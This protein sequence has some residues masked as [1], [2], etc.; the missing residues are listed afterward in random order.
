MQGVGCAIDET[1]K[2]LEDREVPNGEKPYV[3]HT[4]EFLCPY[5]RLGEEGL[6]LGVGRINKKKMTW[7]HFWLGFVWCLEHYL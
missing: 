4:Q 5:C 1:E 6:D 3:L 7:L 2:K